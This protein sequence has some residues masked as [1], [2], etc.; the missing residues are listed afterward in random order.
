MKVKK[1]VFP[2]AGLGT[3]FLPGDQGYGQG[4]ADR[5]RQ[6]HYPIRRE[7]A[8]D[9]GIEQI[10]FVTGRGKKALEDH[11]DR[12]YE[13]ETMLKTKGKNRIAAV[14]PGTGPK[15]RHHCLHPPA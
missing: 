11:F 15:N 6:T 5:G 9:A 12:S 2:V 14:A 1:A 13:L 4:D 3:R 10:I 8:F 7:E